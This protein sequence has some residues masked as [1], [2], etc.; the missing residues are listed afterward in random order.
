MRSNRPT[1]ADL[2]AMKGKKQLSK[3]R[4]FTMEEVEA[5]ARAG[6]EILSVT[7]ELIL[8]P[9]FRDAAPDVFAIPGSVNSFFALKDDVMRDAFRF[10]RA[11][12]DAVY[13]A[14]SLDTIRSL[15]DE[16][17]AVCGHS[18]LI[19]HHSTWTGGFRAVGKTAETAM[20]VWKQVKALEAAGAFAAEIE[21]VPV[22]VASAISVRTSL[23]MISMGAGGGCDA[24]YL[25]SEDILGYNRGHYPRHSK[26]YRNFA[27]EYDRLQAER[28][29]AFSEY[30]ADVRSGAYPEPKHVV[31]IAQGELKQFLDELQQA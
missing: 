6:V 7:P 5:A 11:G 14:A 31:G 20:F 21:V 4:V 1:V 16:H 24:Q 18:G 15:A 26:V 2:R 9:A 10:I 25:F 28:V 30:V 13:C 19:P 23:F 12:A 17:V 3:I 22:E 8:N 27:A 29:A